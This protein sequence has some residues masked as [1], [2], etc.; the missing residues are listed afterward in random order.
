MGKERVHEWERERGCVRER[1][2]GRED[3]ELGEREREREGGR[4]EMT[5]Y[6]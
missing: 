6:S 5:K 1:E 4:T 2:G 3:R